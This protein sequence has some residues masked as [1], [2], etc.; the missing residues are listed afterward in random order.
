MRGTRCLVMALTAAF[1]AYGNGAIGA[2]FKHMGVASCAASVCHG[3]LAAQTDRNVQL[4][5]YRTWS[6]EDRHS[7]AYRT[8]ESAQSKAI[9]QKLGLPSAKTAQICLDCHADS[10]AARGPKF[11]VSDGVGC[12]ACHGGAEKWIESHAEK[13]ATHQRNLSLGMYPTESPAARA[14]LCLTCHMG[15][16]DRM[17]TNYRRPLLWLIDAK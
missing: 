6:Q 4:N 16:G 14:R 7:Q 17:I 5:E 13:T 2:E 3:K 10:A 1:V 9:A 11:L 8:L 15:T 12:E